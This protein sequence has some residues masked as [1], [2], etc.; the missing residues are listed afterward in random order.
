M[1]V[2]TIRE[3]LLEKERNLKKLIQMAESSANEKE[4]GSLRIT[5]F[6]EYPRFYRRFSDENGKKHDQ[7][8]S[9]KKDAEQIKNL[10]QNDYTNIFL[11][12]AYEQLRAVQKA[13]KK[14]DEDALANVF[15]CLHKDRKKL[16]SPFVPDQ[17]ELLRKWDAMEYPSGYFSE[18]TPEIYTERGE[19]VR[20]KSEK[21]IADKYNLL[22]L[23]YKY[24]MPITLMDHKKRV[25]VRPDF[26][27]L[28]VR[29][30]IRRFHEH[31]GKMDD[32]DYIRKTIYKLRLY[33]QN[34]IYVGDQLVLT[35][36]SSL[37][38][39]DMKHLDIMIKRYFL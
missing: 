36:E 37:Q 10:A 26:T 1:S 15:S 30:R 16:V 24:E 35:Y 22:D 29:L 9:K 38:P 39:L 25:S 11:R 17:E 8:L 20:S 27:V 21:I 31:L 7:Y 18:K 6:K 34:G 28:N 32:P 14:L 12:T 19:R 3:M 13:L 4:F 5:S 2:L 33:E 23:H